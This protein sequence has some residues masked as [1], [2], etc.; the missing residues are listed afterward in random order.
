MNNW[1]KKNKYKDAFKKLSSKLIINKSRNNSNADSEQVSNNNNQTE[2]TNQNLREEPKTKTQITF[3]DKVNLGGVV[4]NA[5]IAGCTLYALY[6]TNQSL[7]ISKQSLDFAKN[8]S[9]A[10][11]STSKANFDLTKQSVEAAIKLSQFAD[12]NYSV[13]K[14]GIEISNKNYEQSYKISQKS[15]NETVNQFNK[16][17]TPYIQAGEFAISEIKEGMPLFINYIFLNIT[18][19][20]VKIIKQRSLVKFGVNRI[21]EKDFINIPFEQSINQYL[22]KDAAITNKTT[23]FNEPANQNDVEEVNDEKNYFYIMKEIVYQNLVTKKVRHYK[24]Q[25]KVKRVSSTSVTNFTYIEFL[26]NE[27][28]DE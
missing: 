12:S 8:T 6:L 24:F 14:Q 17:N 19:V 27:N 25:I 7:D 10:S 11:D 5:F 16:S 21:Q 20:P 1:R 2:T 28:F 4:T 18:N 13:T 26:Y 15:F 3:S 23:F 22:I 9:K